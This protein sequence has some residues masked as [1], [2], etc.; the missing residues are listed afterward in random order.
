MNTEKLKLNHLTIE[1]FKS[2]KNKSEFEFAPITLLIGQNNSGKSSVL[3]SVKLLADNFGKD[4]RNKVELKTFL[5]T[6]FDAGQL[7]GRYGNIRN[8][9]SKGSKNNSLKISFEIQDD[10]LMMDL[11]VTIEIEIVENQY[12]TIKE[13]IVEDKYTKNWIYK[14][15]EGYDSFYFNVNQKHAIN[16]FKDNLIH[17]E[18]FLNNI[19]SAQYDIELEITAIIQQYIESVADEI[20]IHIDYE[21]IINMA[22]QYIEI[23]ESFYTIKSETKEKGF[24]WL[25]MF[26]NK[27]LDIIKYF[28]EFDKETKETILEFISIFDIESKY[29]NV[30]ELRT[31]KLQKD[32]RKYLIEIFEHL[33]LQEKFKELTINN[34]GLDY[35]EKNYENIEI[36]RNIYFQNNLKIRAGFELLTNREIDFDIE[37]INEKLKIIRDSFINEMNQYIDEKFKSSIPQKVN[38]FI[39]HSKIFDD[40]N[41]V[42]IEDIFDFDLLNYTNNLSLFHSINQKEY[43]NSN[44]LFSKTGRILEHIK[45]DTFLNLKHL[46]SD[47]NEYF[48][49]TVK[50]KIEYFIDI[51]NPDWDNN[52]FLIQIEEQI[53]EKLSSIQHRI[54]DDNKIINIFD[55]LPDLHS[56]GEGE[57]SQIK[58]FDYN[59]Q[60]LLLCSNDMTFF[61]GLGILPFGFSPDHF[62]R[63][64][65]YNYFSHQDDDDD[66]M[67]FILISLLNKLRNNNLTALVRKFDFFENL[68]ILER[69]IFLRDIYKSTK[70]DDFYEILLTDEKVR[71]GLSKLKY[72]SNKEMS[73][74]Y[75]YFH[76]IITKSFN[77]LHNII[78]TNFQHDI[79]YLPAIKTSLNRNISLENLNDPFVQIIRE[80]FRFN[81]MG[82]IKIAYT[83][84]FFKLLGKNEM[85]EIELDNDSAR[86]KFNLK[87]EN[88]ESVNIVD[89]GHG[90]AH[91]GILCHCLNVLGYKNTNQTIVVEEPEIGLHP[92][93]QSKLADIL[94]LAY[95]NGIQSVVET[96]SEYIVRKLQYLTA[97][98]DLKK[99]D[100]AI[101]YFNLAEND[102]DNERFFRIEIEEDGTL[103]RNFGKGFYDEA[104]NISL[105]LFFERFGKNN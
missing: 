70:M 35:F 69:P 64:N 101:Y 42:E 94:V 66:T 12:G 2:F 4:G 30:D 28:N 20:L 16:I 74:S 59:V 105:D 96:H 18:I 65:K 80:D 27:G 99:G 32:Y 67:L 24:H 31:P 17:Y 7:R 9:L 49:Q 84:E 47:E 100:V 22:I 19:F 21:E 82:A 5:E 3:Q 29:N 37:S 61:K 57:L 83:N 41:Y 54:S 75:D 13:I 91:I 78:R 63:G 92:M 81:N 85:F 6:K 34:L 73:L 55:Y 103:T 68:R 95:K 40:N 44:M 102:S 50:N 48:V 76:E 33:I 45:V 71:I 15:T 90:I 46:L 88:G 52:L 26:F 72:S 77:Q 58:Y 62:L 79:F 8:Y 36:D 93:F 86:V 23:V 89:E 98:G 87:K 97:K 1:N 14:F 11:N 60:V 43:V 51:E 25:N 39:D 38:L 104:N 56:M 53:L 10:V